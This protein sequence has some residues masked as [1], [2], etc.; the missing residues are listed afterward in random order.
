MKARILRELAEKV[1]PK[2]EDGTIR[3]KICAVLPIVEAE[4]AHEILKD[5]RH[6]GKVVLQVREGNK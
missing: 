4:R 3:P 1:W 6:V 5:S 2:I